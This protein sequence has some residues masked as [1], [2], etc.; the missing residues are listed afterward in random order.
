MGPNT[1][2][3]YYEAEELEAAYLA[4]STGKKIGMGPDSFCYLEIR[5]STSSSL[6]WRTQQQSKL[7][8]LRKPQMIQ[9]G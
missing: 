4:V 1:A 8:I 5:L 9:T 7:K 6:G 2:K 3:V